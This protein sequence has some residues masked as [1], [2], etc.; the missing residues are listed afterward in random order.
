MLD[1]PFWWLGMY[2]KR[3]EKAG[4]SFSGAFWPRYNHRVIVLALF[5]LIEIP[6]QDE[7]VLARKKTVV[8]PADPQDEFLLWHSFQA[9]TGFGA[10]TSA[11]SKNG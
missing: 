6:W 10:K 3:F 2:L 9:T 8:R 5:E 11:V 7:F 1:G 4:Q